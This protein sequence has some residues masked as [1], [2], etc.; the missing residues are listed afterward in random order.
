MTGSTTALDF[1]GTVFFFFTV[2]CYMFIL[3]NDRSQN[4]ENS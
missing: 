3:I 2:I 1:Y 4:Y